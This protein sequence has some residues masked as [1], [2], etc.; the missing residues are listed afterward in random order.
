M[1]FHES[2]RNAQI[3]DVLTAHGTLLEVRIHRGTIVRRKRVIHIRRERVLDSR[4]R[5]ALVDERT[6]RRR[7]RGR[8]E[9][10][11]RSRCTTETLCKV[12]ADRRNLM[13]RQVSM[14]EALQVVGCHVRPHG[15][16]TAGNR[17]YGFLPFSRC[18]ILRR[19]RARAAFRRLMTCCRVRSSI[20]PTARS[21]SGRSFQIVMRR[22]AGI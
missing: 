2:S 1:A 13:R 5:G 9:L 4:M 22:A 19:R 18:N 14:P 15:L 10:L 17:H 6:Q 7:E 16:K 11:L 3:C 8:V 20:E 21:L 12:P